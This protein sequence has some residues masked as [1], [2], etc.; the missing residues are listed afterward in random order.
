LFIP[1]S[2]KDQTSKELSFRY[3]AY[4]FASAGWCPNNPGYP[5]IVY[6]NVCAE[7]AEEM[8]KWF[9]ARFDEN[10]W[11]PAW[12]YTVYD[13]AHFHSNTHEVIGAYRGCASIRFGDF[14]GQTIEISAGDAV[15]IPAGVSHQRLAASPD[16]IAVGAY[17]RG[18]DP[19]QIRK[20]ESHGDFKETVA[21]VP[22]PKTD[23]LVQ[24]G[25]PLQMEWPVKTL[26]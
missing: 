26:P 7:D 9:E 23:P 17:P 25:G 20:G 10:G 8:A 14:A 22:V 21:D 11:P 13:F 15:L 4:R 18:F 6:R 2:M 19:D 5:L 1:T 24:R 16:F 3:E 12:R